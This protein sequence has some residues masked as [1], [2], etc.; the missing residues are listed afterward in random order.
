MNSRSPDNAQR[1][2]GNLVCLDPD[3]LSRNYN[4][5]SLAFHVEREL[6]PI[7]QWETTPS[8]DQPGYVRLSP[9]VEPVFAFITEHIVTHL[10]RCLQHD[11]R[12]HH[13]WVLAFI[14]AKKAIDGPPIK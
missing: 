12:R 9:F 10:L 3:P 5:G 8:P 6:Y 4:V 11:I 7:E 13:D 2:I 14:F 1:V